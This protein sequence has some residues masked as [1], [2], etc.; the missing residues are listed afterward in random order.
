M[1]SRGEE[2][3]ALIEELFPICRSITGAGVRETLDR[4]GARI[5]LERHEVPSGTASGSSTSR[6]RTSM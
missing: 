2:M 3:Y 5:P 6:T 4:I 1:S